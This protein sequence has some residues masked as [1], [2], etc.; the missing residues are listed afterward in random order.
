MRNKK[1]TLL[2]LLSTAFLFTGSATQAERREGAGKQPGTEVEQSFMQR[3]FGWGERAEENDGQLDNP[4]KENKKA[5][6]SKSKHNADQTFNESERSLITDY[7]RNEN[8]HRGGDNGTQSKKKELPPG[9]QKKLE[10]GG[11]LPPGWQMKVNRDEVLDA[12]LLSHAQPLPDA[13][14]SSL[15][16][17]QDGTELRRIGDKIIRIMEGNGTVL[18]VIDLADTALRR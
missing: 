15:P 17:L 14:R 11:E 1:L 9:L 6:T 12:E 13:L 4:A 8:A 16:L 3:W 2:A 18:D 5:S 7:Y 10:R